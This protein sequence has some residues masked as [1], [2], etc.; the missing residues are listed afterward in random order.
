MAGH[1]SPEKKLTAGPIVEFMRSRGWHCESLEVGTTWGG[2]PI[3][4]PGRSDWMFCKSI[5]PGVAALIFL[6]AKAP[7]ARMRCNCRPAEFGVNTR[8][9]QVM[10]KRAHKCR[11]C[12]QSEF[13]AAMIAKGF[14]AVQFDCHRA[15]ARWFEEKFKWTI[16]IA[17][18]TEA[19]QA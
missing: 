4:T 14:V 8:G 3:G 17:S 9:K 10:K 16:E 18:D 15:Y 7:G 5:H 11:M 6:E 12:S 13:R 2:A 1:N 19:S